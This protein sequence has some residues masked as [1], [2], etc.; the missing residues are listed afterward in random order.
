MFLKKDCKAVDKHGAVKLQETRPGNNCYMWKQSE[1]CLSGVS[2]ELNIWHQKLGY[3]NV[4]TM[5]KHINHGVNRG[6]LKLGYET[7]FLCGPGN[8][9]K[10]VKKQHNI[11]SYIQ[12]KIALDLVHMK[13]MGSIQV[14][15]MSGRNYIVVLGDDNDGEFLNDMCVKICTDHKIVH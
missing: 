2:K 4:R 6:A 10:Q 5:S 15:S 3:M 1:Q 11:I 13:F 14:E 8:K 9:G 12:S 7:N